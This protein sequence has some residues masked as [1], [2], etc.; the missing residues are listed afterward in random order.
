MVER[1]TGQ[2]TLRE[3]FVE[4]ERL[5]RELIEHIDQGFLPKTHE[6]ARLIRPIH[7]DPPGL[8]VLEDVTV[9]TQASRLL[10]TEAYTE[11]MFTRLGEFCRT[12]DSSVSRILT[13][14]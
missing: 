8:D 7:G 13:E 2:L 1:P 5:T 4:A 11:E 14:G 9:R 12:I 3:M 6:L 10:E